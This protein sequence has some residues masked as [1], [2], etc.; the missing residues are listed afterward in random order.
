MQTFQIVQFTQMFKIVGDERIELDPKRLGHGQ[1][2]VRFPDGDTTR[3]LVMNGGVWTG[4]NSDRVRRQR[5]GILE[6]HAAH[7]T[8]AE[9]TETRV[10]RIGSEIA[11]L[12]GKRGAEASTEHKRLKEALK[13]AKATLAVANSNLAKVKALADVI[14][15]DGAYPDLVQFA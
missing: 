3:H 13:T 9:A 2:I 8:T 1:A 6:T 7:K 11:E 10:S 15:H 14:E 12:K 4:W 5:A